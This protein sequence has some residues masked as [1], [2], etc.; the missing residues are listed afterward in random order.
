MIAPKR[1]FFGAI[2]FNNLTFPIRFI[3]TLYRPRD[4]PEFSNLER[5]RSLPSKTYPSAS[6]MDPLLSFIGYPLFFFSPVK[7]E[8]HS[9]ACRKRCFLSESVVEMPKDGLLLINVTP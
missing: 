6:K 3:S 4:S 8:L 2:E 9:T 7:L 1:L 5:V